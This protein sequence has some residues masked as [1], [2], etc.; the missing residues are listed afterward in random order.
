V[1][2][3]RFISKHLAGRAKVKASGGIEN[4]AQAM[5]ILEAGAH[6]IGSSVAP[7]IVGGKS[8]GSGSY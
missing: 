6:L 5:T 2:E 3:I 7:A 1:K 4:Y 8:E